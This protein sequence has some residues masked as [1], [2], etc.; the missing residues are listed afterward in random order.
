MYILDCGFYNLAV[1]IEP[2]WNWV[3]FPHLIFP[4]EGVSPHDV[5][6]RHPTGWRYNLPL[7]SFCES[8]FSSN[9]ELLGGCQHYCNPSYNLCP[10]WPP[11][12]TNMST[13]N[14]HPLSKVICVEPYSNVSISTA[15]LFPFDHF[16]HHHQQLMLVFGQTLHCNLL[17]F[18]KLAP[19]TLRDA[20]RRRNA[21]RSPLVPDLE[22]DAEGG[23]HEGLDRKGGASKSIHLIRCHGNSQCCR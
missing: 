3:D 18:Q 9:W 20:H 12:P 4:R 23:F 6:R 8:V 17:V 21:M 2:C 11:I 10:C 22:R 7:S 13:S 1:F 19:W 14:H 5:T 15:L 16:N